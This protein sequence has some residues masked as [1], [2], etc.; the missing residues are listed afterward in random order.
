MEVWEM[1]GHGEFERVRHGKDQKSVPFEHPEQAFEA[2]ARGWRDVFQNLA[3]DDEIIL[4]GVLAS[5]A[6]K[7]EKRRA[8]ME[9]ISVVELGSE[10]TG[11]L[12]TVA[13]ADGAQ[14]LEARE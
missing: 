6:G 13:G 8:V 7:V 12:G 10:A 14:A 3:G 1:L 4:A 11:I 5:G 9:G 2:G